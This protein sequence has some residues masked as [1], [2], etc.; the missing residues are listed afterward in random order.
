MINVRKSVGTA[1]AAIALMLVAAGCSS[2]PE[3]LVPASPAS[4]NSPAAS[5]QTPGPVEQTTKATPP[6]PSG[7]VYADATQNKVKV[8]VLEDMQPADVGSSADA[9]MAMS[10]SQGTTIH[11]ATPISSPTLPGESDLLPALQSNG[12]QNVSCSSTAVNL[13]DEAFTCSY[14]SVTNGVTVS[15]QQLYVQSGA[16][17]VTVVTVG[18]LDPAVVAEIVDTISQC[19]EPL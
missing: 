3:V 2:T 14:E 6:L 5:S 15:G 12:A 17:T 10:N 4:T 19:I 16:S 8:P 11:V 9:D 13:G 1:V 18:A 7:Y